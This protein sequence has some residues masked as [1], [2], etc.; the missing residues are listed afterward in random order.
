MIVM[1]F[2]GNLIIHRLFGMVAKMIN[3]RCSPLLEFAFCEGFL[4]NRVVF[5]R[6]IPK[7]TPISRSVVDSGG[8][9]EISSIASST[10]EQE[11]KIPE[12]ASIVGTNTSLDCYPTVLCV[13]PGNL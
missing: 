2:A 7:K 5:C 3:V 11:E 12:T 6:N 13:F 9:I 4:Q 1:V 10:R 8:D